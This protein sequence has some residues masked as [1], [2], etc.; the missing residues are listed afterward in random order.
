VTRHDFRACCGGF[1]LVEVLVA[2]LVLA[3]G[4]LGLAG[5][6][7]A[8]MKSNHS[9]YL[10]SQATVAAYDLLDRMRADPGAFTGDD[11]EYQSCLDSPANRFDEWECLIDSLDLPAPE[12][13]G[14]PRGKF[15][16]SDDNACGTGNCEVV[17]SWNDRRGERK[18]PP[19]AV[20]EGGDGGGDG[21]E[22]AGRSP[23]TMSFRV[24]SRIA[25]PI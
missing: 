24:C 6:Q 17:V 3:V 9:A 16:C 22:E 10:R 18:Q 8:S 20:D 21:A 2:A 19:S 25:E 4:L 1:T 5:L 13:E 15:D 23:S 12:D 7:L 14:V 11:D